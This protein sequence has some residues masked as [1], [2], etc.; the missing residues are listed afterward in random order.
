[1]V[2]QRF[3]DRFEILAFEGHGM[4]GEVEDEL[5]R[6]V[7]LDSNKVGVGECPA[8]SCFKDDIQSNGSLNLGSPFRDW[9]E[10]CEIGL[11]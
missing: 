5:A 3:I 7:E 2:E 8:I 11:E 1:M 6:F 4:A 10:C 9:A